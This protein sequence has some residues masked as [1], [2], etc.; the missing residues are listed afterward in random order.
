M[1]PHKRIYIIS[2]LC[3]FLMPIGWMSAQTASQREMD[4]Q[5]ANDEAHTRYENELHN[6]PLFERQLKDILGYKTDSRKAREWILSLKSA[7]H[8]LSK[9]NF[10]QAESAYFEAVKLASIF[11]A[12]D[13]RYIDTIREFSVFYASIKKYAAAESKLLFLAAI[14]KNAEGEQSD[15]YAYALTDLGDLYK[16]WGNYEKALLNYESA[17]AIVE[18][19]W[20]PDSTITARGLNTLAMLHYA[21]RN[22]A[23][24]DELFKRTLRIFESKLGPEH[25]FTIAVMRNYTVF[26]K[27]TGR[28]QEA[29][30]IEQQAADNE[31]L[32]IQ[33]DRAV[34]QH[35]SENPELY[36][37]ID[38]ILAGNTKDAKRLIAQKSLLN[39]EDYEGSTPLM[40]AS[41]AGNADLAK[42]LIKAGADVHV[43]N[44]RG[45]TALS[46]ARESK[47]AEI[48]KL[49]TKAGAT[50]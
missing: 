25:Q 4:I 44:K 24:A 13:E 29:A 33:T 17:Q 19:L 45:K 28:Q 21:M 30:V 20:G 22:N 23:R 35:I 42:S 34:K 26:L 39:G 11:G 18:T 5:R 1:N 16:I 48:I 47:S 15:A 12:K 41:G 8:E 46:E 6:Q 31:L 36:K 49:L 32:Q 14:V 2:L 7:R 10:S 43:K 38:A 3:L 40:V 27:A 37:L 50:E 9:R